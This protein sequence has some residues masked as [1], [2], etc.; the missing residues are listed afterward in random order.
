VVWDRGPV[1]CGYVHKGD[2]AKVRR[3]HDSEVAALGYALQQILAKRGF[4]DTEGTQVPVLEMSARLAR[5]LELYGEEPVQAIDGKPAPTRVNALGSHGKK[6]PDCGAHALQRVD[7][8]DRCANCG[9][10]GS[11]G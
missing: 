8:C 10:Q 1:Q 7:G 4:L 5:Q 2:G 3:W 11:C 6:C 9:H